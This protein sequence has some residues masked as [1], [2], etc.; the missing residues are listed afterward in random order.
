MNAVARWRHEK[1]KRLFSLGKWCS[2][3]FFCVGR[4]KRSILPEYHALC[5]DGVRHGENGLGKKGSK[6][7]ETGRG[8]AGI[9]QVVDSEVREAAA[10]GGNGNEDLDM[11]FDGSGG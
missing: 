6:G 8:G 7:S 2:L 1:N 5:D 10:K 11:G 4:A 9:G 3:P